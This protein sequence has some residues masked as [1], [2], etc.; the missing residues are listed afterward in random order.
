[1]TWFLLVC[2][3]ING[4][5]AMVGPFDNIA[6]CD[7]ARLQVLSEHPDFTAHCYQS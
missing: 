1:M 2:G 4:G 6:R 7:Y 5:C 3:L